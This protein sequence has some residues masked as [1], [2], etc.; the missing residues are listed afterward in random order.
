MEFTQSE[1]KLFL[2]QVVNM[3]DI[4]LC[5]GAEVNRVEDV[6]KRMARAYG[7][8]FAD[9]FVIT[10]SIVVSMRFP[11]GEELTE[12]RRI[13]YSGETNLARV[14]AISDILQDCTKAP[15]PPEKLREEIHRILM[16]V[17]SRKL[18]LGGAVGAA[19][20]CLF[21]GGSLPE[22]LTAALI[23]L[24]IYWLQRK[25]GPLCPNR[26]SFNLISA[27]TAGLLIYG[28]EAL[29]PFLDAGHILSGDIMLLIP[30]VSLTNSVRDML[31]GDTASGALRFI[32]SLLWTVGLA[33]GMIL[34]MGLVEV[35]L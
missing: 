10:S 13:H 31:V 5:S 24:Y 8:F 3:G 33:V 12:T 22:A 23:S 1:A 15:L 14:E 32:E 9:I 30:G 28:L 35:L 2:H 20:F 4:L 34:A 17:S 25:L 7:I 11:D 26:I 18:I 21:F 16:P 19:A 29:L 27:F 6:L